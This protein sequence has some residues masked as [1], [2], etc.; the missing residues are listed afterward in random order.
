MHTSEQIILMFLNIDES[1][2]TKS[3]SQQLRGCGSDRGAGK[4]N[5]GRELFACFMARVSSSLSYFY[6]QGLFSSS[7]FGDVLHTD[8]TQCTQSY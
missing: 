5:T 7:H 3:C 8:E 2:G 4:S 1:K 6:F